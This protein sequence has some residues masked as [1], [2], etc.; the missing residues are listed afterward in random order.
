M[1]W[2]DTL[3][4]MRPSCLVPCSHAPTP[5]M[6]V[7]HNRN[8]RIGNIL[9][10][11]AAS[12]ACAATQVLLCLCVVGFLQ[13]E[14]R[15]L[16]WLHAACKAQLASFDTTL[17]EDLRLMEQQQQ[18]EQKQQMEGTGTNQQGCAGTSTSTPAATKQDAA[19]SSSS[20]NGAA[21]LS[22]GLTCGGLA[23]QWRV[24]HKRIL[25]RTLQ[26]TRAAVEAAAASGKVGGGGGAR[27]RGLGPAGAPP[28]D[29]QE[30]QRRMR[31]G[32]R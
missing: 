28:L 30:L 26:L 16:C 2:T 32:L 4:C 24:L 8:A 17:E 15:V 25:H 21:A 11:T 29:L 14:E 23:L 27:G 6:S 1:G 9:A 5:Q 7:S 19:V 18:Q 22:D 12:L 13:G 3:P 31:A 20:S 10:P